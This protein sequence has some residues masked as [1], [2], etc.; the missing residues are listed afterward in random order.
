MASHFHSHDPGPNDIARGYEGN[1]IRARAFLVFIVAFVVSAAVIHTIIWFVLL[2]TQEAAQAENAARFP[3]PL[4]SQTTM[5][6]VRRPPAPNLQPS[7]EHDRVAW[8]DMDDL[9][10]EQEDSL[11]RIKPEQGRGWERAYTDAVREPSQPLNQLRLPADAADAVAP[12]VSSSRS[13]A[14][15]TQ[16]T[17]QRAGGAAPTRAE[18][19]TE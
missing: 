1:D 9:R 19:G 16:S 13:G 6:V 10:H 8:R 7:P 4:F 2:G 5:D 12:R 14:P 3:P 18:G 17:T 15:A 11:T